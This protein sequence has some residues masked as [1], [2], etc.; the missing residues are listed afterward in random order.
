M[1][2][3]GSDSLVSSNIKDLDVTTQQG[4]D[5]FLRAPE[6][7]GGFIQAYMESIEQT[8]QVLGH[9][10]LDH[11]GRREM[12]ETLSGVYTMFAAIAHS[13]SKVVFDQRVHASELKCF[14]KHAMNVLTPIADTEAW[15][16]TGILSNKYDY[17]ILEAIS[18][19]CLHEKFVKVH[20]E[21]KWMKFLAD[22][23]AKCQHPRHVGPQFARYLL[24]IAHHTNLTQEQ[25]ME[26]TT[27]VSYR[28]IEKSGLLLQ[29]LRVVTLKQDNNNVH[30]MVLDQLQNCPKLLRKSFKEGKPCYQVLQDLLH[31][32]NGYPSTF[33]ES[34]RTR[35]AAVFRLSSMAS[36]SANI[37]NDKNMENRLCRKCGNSNAFDN[38]KLLACS[39]CKSAYYCSRECQLADW[40]QHKS[41]CVAGKIIPSKASQQTLNNYLDQNYFRILGAFW[42]KM[43]EW[44]V[45]RTE[46]ILDLNFC[47]QHGSDDSTSPALKGEYRVA[48]TNDYL[49]QV[50]EPEW[51]SHFTEEAK[52]SILRTVRDQQER[53]LES[54]LFVVCCF[55]PNDGV[56]V[57]RTKL[58][59]PITKKSMFD[60]DIVAAFGNRDWE[61]L[62]QRLKGCFPP[63]VWHKWRQLSGTERENQDIDA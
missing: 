40:K 32:R 16:L 1:T 41:R 26:V 28:A 14:L 19:L 3:N 38:V 51:F 27:E 44:N 60:D 48:I 43:Q 21:M 8:H 35:L 47:A 7:D 45:G 10:N 57:C 50:D 2:T 29:L 56:T 37:Q 13:A 34:I 23:C 54:H 33:P 9:G 25:S 4:A 55:S 39:R 36:T 59:H 61:T 31:G 58:A 6:F 20:I 52:Q 18:F 30:R 42:E 22:I 15:A 17:G 11:A 46:L 62:E 5:D 12:S 24:R 49:D 63:D 53:G